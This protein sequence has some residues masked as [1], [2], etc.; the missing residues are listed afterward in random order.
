VRALEKAARRAQVKED[1]AQQV[2]AQ[3]ELLSTEVRLAPGVAMRYHV[4]AD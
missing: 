2:M 4:L 3:N 1:L